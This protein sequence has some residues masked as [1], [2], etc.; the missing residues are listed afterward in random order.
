MYVLTRS[1]IIDKR[2]NFLL[3]NI[4]CRRFDR[5]SVAKNDPSYIDLNISFNFG[6]RNM[7]LSLL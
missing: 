6:K 2:Y 3:N 7:E 5:F 1:V 4:F